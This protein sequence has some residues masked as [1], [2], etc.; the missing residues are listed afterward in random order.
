V[1]LSVRLDAGLAGWRKGLMGLAIQVGE[2]GFTHQTLKYQRHT[3]KF[4]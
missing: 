3:L 1:G 2:P 4:Q